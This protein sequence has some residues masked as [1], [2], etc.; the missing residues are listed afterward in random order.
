MLICG[1]ILVAALR[2]QRAATHTL[3]DAVPERISL[4]LVGHAI[5]RTEEVTSVHDLH[6]WSLDSRE[7]ALSARVALTRAEA[8]P[9]ILVRL[10]SLLR[11]HFGIAHV[12]LQ[13]EVIPEQVMTF[14]RAG[15][16]A[17]PNR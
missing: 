4:P 14:H 8:W 15:S 2:L 3:L 10:Q 7:T 1:L 12:T 11:E 13:S 17:E 6:S 9:E 16:P 5:T